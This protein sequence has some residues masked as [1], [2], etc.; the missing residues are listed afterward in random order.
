MEKETFFQ[1]LPVQLTEEELKQRGK[2]LAKTHYDISEVER[3]KK[4]KIGRAHV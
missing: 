2:D 3:H 1:Q 4:E